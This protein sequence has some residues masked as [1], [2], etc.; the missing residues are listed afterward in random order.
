M[1]D[2]DRGLVEAAHARCLAIHPYTL[3]EEPEMRE[4][5]ELGV[6]GMF[7]DFPNRLE[8]VLGEGA[9]GGNRRGH[10]SAD[11]SNACLS[12]QAR[13]CRIPAGSR[14]AVRCVAGCA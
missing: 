4:M 9:A 10:R 3:L 8:G 11:A 14:S 5:I 6:D 7:T 1:D 2:V 12:G 13:R